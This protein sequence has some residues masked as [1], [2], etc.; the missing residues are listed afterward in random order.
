MCAHPMEMD[1]RRQILFISYIIFTTI[2]CRLTLTNAQPAPGNF[3]EHYCNYAYTSNYTSNS[4]FKTNLDNL[5]SFLS[6]DARFY[7]FS[8]GENPDRVYVIALCR[9]DVALDI[10]S[11]CLRDANTKLRELCPR[12][13]QSIGWYDRC[14]LR[15]WDQPIFNMWQTL[16][17]A[18]TYNLNTVSNGTTGQFNQAVKTLLS[19]LLDKASRGTSVQKFATGT[20]GTGPDNST[21]IYALAECTPDLSRQNCSDCLNLTRVVLPECC[22][23]RIGGRVLYPSCNFRYE[24]GPFYSET[25]NDG[26]P[27]TTNSTPPQPPD[28]GNGNNRTRNVIIIV[29]STIIF[30]ILV[31]ACIWIFMRKRKQ[32]KWNQMNEG[33]TSME[34]STVESLQF[35]FDT[36]RVAT[37]EFSDANKLGEGGFG[38]VYKGRLSNGRD[39]AVKRLSKTSSQGDVEFKNEVLLMANLQHRNLVRLL[40]FCLKGTE[41]L[42]VYEFIANASLD[43]FIF[44]P[45]KRGHLDGSMR[46]KIIGGIAR[47][48]LYLHED[49]RVRIIHRDLKASN[50]LLDAEMNPKIADFGMARIFGLEET[51]A[52]TRNIV[53]TYGYMAPEYAM[54]GQFSVKS[55]VYSFGILVLEMISGH[56]NSQSFG[57]EDS[58]EYL[59]S[60]A[61]KNWKEGTHSKFIDPTILDG[62]SSMSNIL[63]CIHIG[64]LCV[65]E[66]VVD[67]P[68]MASIVNMLS[69]VSYTL[70][71]PSEPAFLS[72]DP[73]NP[74]VGDHSKS[75]DTEPSINEVSISMLSGRS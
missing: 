73:Q 35:D 47:G 62:S 4:V 37:N 16:P 28:P 45:E 70:K 33:E 68:T 48:L 31:I 34:I 46:Y 65:Q 56:K 67:R 58:I 5:I 11:S 60:H 64:L 54:F 57:N 50:I 66:K 53:G 69:S 55:D 44:D 8:I 25:P 21:T 15:Y 9:G 19:N 32:R 72:I 6:P 38:S 22:S 29:I 52:S 59:V 41:R 12:E 18:Y 13:K 75:T 49:S 36:I 61:W 24:I 43:K 71:L 17:N 27:P 74:Q 42:L 1:S 7:N 40:G 3:Q 10:C 30:L 26:R 23:G 2:F 63:R 39:M 51:Q 14:M 20:I